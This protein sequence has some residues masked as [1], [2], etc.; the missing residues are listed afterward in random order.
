MKQKIFS[1][2]FFVFFV[3]IFGYFYAE[4]YLDFY[5]QKTKLVQQEQ[6]VENALA[7]FST[8]SIQQVHQLWFAVTPD[9]QVLDTL[10][11]K[12]DTSENRVFLEVYIFTE[13]RILEALKKAQKRGVDVRVI[14]EKNPYKA[15][16]LNDAR[17]SDL[18]KSG[19]NVVWSNAKNYALNHAK[20]MIIDDEAIIST[21]NMS[22]ST[23][24]KNRDFFVFTSD[25]PLIQTLEEVFEWDFQGNI[26]VPYH[27]NL[28]LSPQYS[29]QKLTRLFLEAQ[30][31]LDIYFQYLQDDELLQTLIQ[32]AQKW[33]QVQIV[34]DDNYFD[35]NPDD[36][37]NLQSYGIDIR[38][39]SSRSM[40]AKAILVDRKALFIGSINFSTYSLDFNREV[41][42]II[43]DSVIIEQ[44]L[45][46]FLGD[47]RA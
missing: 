42:I 10:V 11:Q 12:I 36:I 6:L 28:V 44:F 15:P 25:T 34:I 16:R 8:E 14:L 43:N 31:S 2:L 21:G 47:F 39:Y 45:E 18:Q 20:F 35:E 7:D 5:N 3:A 30:E 37:K 29:R 38:K 17:F 41:G 40:H 26:V 1:I 22:Y 32:Q 4:E 24:T 19:I 27:E 23:F 9:I 13:K 46:I 33:V